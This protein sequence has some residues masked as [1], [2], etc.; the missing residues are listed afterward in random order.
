MNLQGFISELVRNKATAFEFDAALAI[1]IV[2]GSACLTL[3]FTH[4]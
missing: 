3:V 4:V 2:T 1:F